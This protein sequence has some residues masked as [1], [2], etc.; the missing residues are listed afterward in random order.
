MKPCCCETVGVA[1][2]VRAVAGDLEGKGRLRGR[3]GCQDLLDVRSVRQGVEERDV[4]GDVI[5][6]R[7][8]VALAQLVEVCL[9]GFIQTNSQHGAHTRWDVDSVV[10]AGLS[11][12]GGIDEAQFRKLVTSGFGV[13]HTPGDREVYRRRTDANSCHQ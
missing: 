8:E 11:R 2:T 5:P 6:L 7:R 13:F 1:F 10:S 3:E 12:E 9:G 4:R